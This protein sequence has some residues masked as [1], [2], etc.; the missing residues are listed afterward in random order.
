MVDM[1]QMDIDIL[2]MRFEYSD[3]D[4]VWDFEYPDLD[5]D[6]SEL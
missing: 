3:S 1:I 6:G 4:M 2:N 5:I